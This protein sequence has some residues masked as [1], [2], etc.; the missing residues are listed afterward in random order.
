[1]AET[2][3]DRDREV[4]SR[5][6]PNDDYNS[7]YH[8]ENMN[9]TSPDVHGI[10]YSY[11]TMCAIVKYSQTHTFTSIRRRYRQIKYKEQLRRI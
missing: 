5:Y 11:D 10:K 8:E 1:M 6:M 9:D 2:E 4:R 3:T 7:D